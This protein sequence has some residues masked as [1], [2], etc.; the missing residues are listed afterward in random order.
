ML[1]DRFLFD[2]EAGT[3][4][5]DRFLQDLAT[6]YGSVDSVLLWHSYPNIGVDDRN[7]FEMA[8]SLPQLAQLVSDFK[9]AGVRV[10][11][12]YNPWDT[13]TNRSMG[14]DVEELVALIQ[15]VGADGFN[16]CVRSQPRARITPYSA[17]AWPSR[18]LAGPGGVHFVLVL[19][20]RRDT[21][22]GITNSFYN[23]SKTTHKNPVASQPE[24]GADQ[25]AMLKADGTRA[26]PS[27]TG[28]TPQWNP[29]SWNYWPFLPPGTYPCRNCSSGSL[30]V[31]GKSTA[32]G[33]GPP[34]VSRYRVLDS[35]HM[36]QICERWA[37]ERTDGLQHA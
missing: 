27:E 32:A 35:R 37:I 34:S 6:R 36:A 9:R 2:R 24:C 26:E 5:V 12:P 1:H 28:A 29:L 25:R 11:L 13:G 8:R 22:F 17:V 31:D 30:V 15:E 23:T 18:S 19:L 3:W 4:T 33:L 7:Q 16:G 20:A 10:L 21:M 14:S